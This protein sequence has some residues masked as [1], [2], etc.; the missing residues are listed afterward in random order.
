M[1]DDKNKEQPRIADI[2]LK[3]LEKLENLITANLSEKMVNAR[4]ID[5]ARLIHA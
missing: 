4:T 5:V 3:S 2:T 1:F